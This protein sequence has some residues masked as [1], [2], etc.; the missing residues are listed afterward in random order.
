MESYRNR[1]T[2]LAGTLVDQHNKT[3]NNM[4]D[5]I[6]TLNQLRQ[7]SINDTESPNA[8]ERVSLDQDSRQV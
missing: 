3:N 6:H 7:L 8:L 1:E 4:N 2:W 5:S